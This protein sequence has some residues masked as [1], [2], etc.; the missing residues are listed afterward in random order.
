M[1]ITAIIDSSFLKFF[2]PPFRD[3]SLMYQIL[4]ILYAFYNCHVPWLNIVFCVKL[5]KYGTKIS[6]LQHSSLIS[7]SFKFVSYCS[8]VVSKCFTLWWTYKRFFLS[9]TKWN[10]DFTIRGI[11][12]IF[13][14]TIFMSLCYDIYIKHCSFIASYH[15]DVCNKR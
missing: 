12:I 14:T 7:F 9:K 6:A 3:E 10:L 15:L 4:S 11:M 5:S 13:M 1:K 2:F 8:I